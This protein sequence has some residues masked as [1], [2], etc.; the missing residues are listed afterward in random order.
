LDDTADAVSCEQD[1]TYRRCG[2]STL[3]RRKHSW[4]EEKITS[5][6]KKPD[7]EVE[8]E[9]SKWLRTEVVNESE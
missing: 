1:I 9:A 3:C 7:P 4:T 6:Q 8:L 5:N 2:K